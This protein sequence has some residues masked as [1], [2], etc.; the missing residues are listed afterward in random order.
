M[1]LYEAPLHSPLKIVQFLDPSAE[2]ELLSHGV[3]LN[4]EIVLRNKSGGKGPLVFAEGQTLISLPYHY[5]LQIE[6][7]VLPAA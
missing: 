3:H 5:A 2:L 7:V 4:D 1:L 6:V